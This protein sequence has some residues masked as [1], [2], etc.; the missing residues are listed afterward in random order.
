[1]E[2]FDELDLQKLI[3]NALSQTEDHH[4]F[5]SSEAYLGFAET[6]ILSLIYSRLENR[7]AISEI[8]QLFHDIRVDI[9][10]RKIS[11]NIKDLHTV[12]KNCRKC[13]I[14]SV[15]ELPKWNVENPD[16]VI[17]V[18]SPSISPEAITLMVN[19]FKE[20]GFSSDQ[21]CLTY[22]NRCPVRRKYEEQE[23]INCSPY[24]HLELQLLNPKLI[25]CLGATPASVLFGSQIKIKET[26]GN[27]MWLGYWPIL[28]T[29]SPM[30]ILKSGGNT[31]E[32]FS[33]DIKQA[34]DFI[35][36][37]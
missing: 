12:T 20:A 25:L 15:P 31:P 23:V 13:K 14:D 21:L 26:R 22:V 37:R 6:D 4:P 35:H 16:V 24:L 34:Y 33:I 1:M 36:K 11:T 19:A 28:V 29:Y 9:L 5:G 27:I 17:V 7:M 18:D 3:E 10:S 30:Y 2:D 32:H 8:T